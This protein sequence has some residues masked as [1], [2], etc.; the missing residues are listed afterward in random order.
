MHWLQILGSEAIHQFD[1]GPEKNMLLY[2]STQPPEYELTKLQNMTIDIFITTTSGD[3]YCLK[4]DFKM[5][6]ETFK[7]AKI[8]TKDVG[9][10]NHL[11]YLWGKNAHVDIY[12]DIL[13]FLNDK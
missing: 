5:M 1:Y 12:A 10:Y 8:F 2:N 13:N 4:E 6:L 9:N 11:D 7:N 3:P